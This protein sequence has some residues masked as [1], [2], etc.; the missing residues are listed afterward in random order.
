[1]ADLMKVVTEGLQL[2]EM[3]KTQEEVLKGLVGLC[4]AEIY[5]NQDNKEFRERYANAGWKELLYTGD[6]MDTLEYKLVHIAEYWSNDLC[7]M[8]L[9]SLDKCKHTKFWELLE[10]QEGYSRDMLNAFFKLV[11]GVLDSKYGWMW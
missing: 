3:D 1:M 6:E 2:E 4:L 8:F 10:R 11:Y 5:K 7:L 9:D